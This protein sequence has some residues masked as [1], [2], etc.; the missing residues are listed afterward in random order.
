MRQVACVD[1][2]VLKQTKQV[3]YW[4]DNWLHKAADTADT[5]ESITDTRQAYATEDVAPKTDTARRTAT[6]R[7]RAA[8]RRC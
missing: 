4:I 1:T 8:R 3:A 7:T 6:R 5:R 2:I